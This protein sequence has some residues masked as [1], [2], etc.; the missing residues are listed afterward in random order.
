MKKIASLL[1][2]L[3]SNLI[4]AQI[5]STIFCLSSENSGAYLAKLNSLTGALTD[6]SVAPVCT[7]GVQIPNETI[8]PFN[9]IYYFISGNSSLVAVDLNTGSVMSSVPLT[10]SNAAYFDQI[11]F[12]ARD[13]TIYC[14]A[15]LPYPG[16]VYLAK[17][18]PSTGIVSIISPNTVSQGEQIP[19]AA[20]DPFTKTFYYVNENTYLVGVN[21]QSGLLVSSAPISNP[22]AAYF[23]Q[24]KFSLHDSTLYGLA[25]DNAQ[26]IFLSRINVNTGLVTNISP[27]SVG[28]S[29]QIPNALIDPCN[30]LFYF[31]D[32]SQTLKGIDLNTG[33]VARSAS[34][35]SPNTNAVI[36]IDFNYKCYYKNSG[37][38]G[39]SIEINYELYPNP[40]A[41]ILHINTSAEIKD[42]TLMNL[43]GEELPV[44]YS[45]A[46]QEIDLSGLEDGVYF[47]QLKMPGS[48]IIKKVI[49]Q[50]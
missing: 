37:V 39:Y 38:Q 10:N 50:H 24:M 14:L 9:S 48:G 7:N 29:E 11:Q 3:C 42:I 15:R 43:V 30:R 22:N 5:D 1:L 26:N 40:S 23:D 46:S 4:Y 45:K 17:I 35:V 12:S 31:M 25:R 21:L 8:D 44:L 13:T 41:G 47:V 34:I 6:I 16:G 28:S 27:S 2:F 33:L 32:G 36:E 20:I 19:N 49:L 18:N